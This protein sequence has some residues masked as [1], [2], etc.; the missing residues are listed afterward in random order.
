MELC[1]TYPAILPLISLCPH[2][3][4]ILKNLFFLPDSSFFF[5]FIFP[6]FHYIIS[7]P[8]LSP[9]ALY[10]PPLSPLTHV[11]SSLPPTS[12]YF[13]S[14]TSVPFL[15]PLP[16]PLPP[17]PPPPIFPLP[18]PYPPPYSYTPSSLASSPAIP[19]PLPIP[20]SPTSLALLP[21]PPPYSPPYI[22]LPSLSSTLPLPI[23]PSPP[24]VIRLVGPRVM[25]PGKPG[26]WF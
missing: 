16:L 24:L 19:L 7:S 25:I 14:P 8:S 13:P 9:I 5:L 22:P 20:Y 18:I 6:S 12:L 2:V 21:I 1:C 15:I 23:C 11:C 3:Y 17:P 26:I 10:V 4:L